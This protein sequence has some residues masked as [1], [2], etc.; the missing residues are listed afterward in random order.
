M[1]NKLYQEELMDHFKNPRNAGRLK[2][3]DVSSGEYNP[4]CGDSICVD[5]KIKDDI[6]EQIGFVGKG[7]VISQAASSMTMQ[8]C[9]GKS[10]EKILELKKEDVL[11]L[12]KIKLGPNRLR[13]A[14][15]GLQA[16]Q[17]GLKK[18]QKDNS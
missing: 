16:L 11:S 9:V 14:L 2:N 5:C 17:N 8:F 1:T 18:Y 6:V 7:C 10:I 4:S 15:L 12:I 13:C 3:A